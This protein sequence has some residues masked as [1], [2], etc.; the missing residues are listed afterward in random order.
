MEA[1]AARLPASLGKFVGSTSYIIKFFVY[2]TAI[3]I[4]NASMTAA[5]LTPSAAGLAQPTLAVAAG[6]TSPRR[7]RLRPVNP[8]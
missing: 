4:G 6:R 2:V 1:D 5:V 8:F 3:A 7:N